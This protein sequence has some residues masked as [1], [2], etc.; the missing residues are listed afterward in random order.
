M[1]MRGSAVA[2]LVLFGLSVFLVCASVH[3]GESAFADVIKEVIVTLEK[4]TATLATIQDQ[5]TAKA[6]RP[7]LRKTAAKWQE[8]RD[9]EDK[10]K[11]PAKEEKDR[12]EKEYK[13]KL[14]TAIKKL[15]REFER[16]KRVPGGT[17]ALQEISSVLK[18]KT[19]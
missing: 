1:N 8:I 15:M 16:V 18:K 7:E 14:Q 19:K 12:L 11:P 6:A 17:E 2:G 9:K 13:E 5:E 10:L 4:M 3:G